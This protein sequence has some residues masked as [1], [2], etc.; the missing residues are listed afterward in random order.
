[1]VGF[2]TR[3]KYPEQKRVF[4]ALPGLENAEFLRFGSIHRNTYL[5]APS[6]LSEDLRT[7]KRPD[8]YFAGQ[9]TGVEGYVESTACGLLVAWHVLSHLRG[10][11][12]PLPPATTAFGALY[13]HLRHE[14]IYSDY[15]PSNL[16]WSFFAPIDKRR[17]EKRFE[18]RSRL[19]LRAQED[20][21]RW[22][23]SVSG[24]LKTL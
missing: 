7:S 11:T 9:I 12:L 14:G 21:E 6:V 19:A 15:A 18:K 24:G 20:C 17:R 23:A 2:Q 1:M 8:L 13:R 16:N 5:H 10:E 22:W 4:R 3:L